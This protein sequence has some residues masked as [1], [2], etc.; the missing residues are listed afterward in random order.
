MV[1]WIMGCDNM[2]TGESYMVKSTVPS[3]LP[4]Y[5]APRTD[6]T[7]LTPIYCMQ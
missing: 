1:L 4:W 6:R 7:A 2:A 5:N 3:I